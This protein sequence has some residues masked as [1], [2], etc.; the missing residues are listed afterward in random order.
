MIATVPQTDSACHMRANL[1]ASTIQA[2]TRCESRRC[3]PYSER[4]LSAQ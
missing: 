3:S 4:S 2:S 1:H